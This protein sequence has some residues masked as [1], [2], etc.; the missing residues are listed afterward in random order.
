MTYKKILITTQSGR[1]LECSG[2]HTLDA[3][4][5]NGFDWRLDKLRQTR[6]NIFM[7]WSAK[8]SAPQDDW[9]SCEAW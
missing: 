4:S 8:P 5:V 9:L 3:P 7:D 6:A 1:S 2:Q